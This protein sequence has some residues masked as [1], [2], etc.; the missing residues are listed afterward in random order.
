MPSTTEVYVEGLN[1][2]LRA[3]RKLPKEASAE[4][5]SASQTIATRYMVPAWQKAALEAGPWGPKL[6]QNIKARRDRVPSVSIGGNRK[7]F[8]GG[9]T[10]NMVRYPSHS[11]QARQSFAPFTKTDWISS[12]T[13]IK[14]ALGEWAKAVDQII[15]KW[16]V[17]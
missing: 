10:A 14:P 6:A 16:E 12:A 1:D 4:L 11:G 8:S 13:Y 9:A 3:F 7:I 5:R 15:A 17:M 2:V